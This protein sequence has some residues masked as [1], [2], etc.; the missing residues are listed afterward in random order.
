[1][2]VAPPFGSVALVSAFESFAG[3]EEA[4]AAAE[5]ALRTTSPYAKCRVR[6]S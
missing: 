5:S 3:S 1:M 4:H 6:C 2:S